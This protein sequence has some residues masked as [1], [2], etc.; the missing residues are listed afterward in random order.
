MEQKVLK[1]VTV[2]SDR[3]TAKRISAYAQKLVT[4]EK[5]EEKQR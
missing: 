3:E 1:E 4:N 5:K 2:K